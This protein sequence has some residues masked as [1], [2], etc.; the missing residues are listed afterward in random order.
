MTQLGILQVCT[1]H[2]GAAH[3]GLGGRRALDRLVHPRAFER[4]DVLALSGEEHTR[5]QVSLKEIGLHQRGIL[6]VGAA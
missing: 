6:E 1:G 2:V 4:S 3:V 5:A